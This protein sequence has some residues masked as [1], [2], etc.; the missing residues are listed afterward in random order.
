MEI[1][2]RYHLC[3]LVFAPFFPAE[4]VLM[5]VRPR[6]I[7]EKLGQLS[8]GLAGAR[9][10]RP[11][12]PN[13]VALRRPLLLVAAIV[14]LGGGVLVAGRLA[15]G[16]LTAARPQSA[17]SAPAN[18]VCGEPC[19]LYQTVW[20]GDILLADSAQPYVDR[21]GY[22][23]PFE[24]V[25]PLLKADFVVGNSEGPITER[26]EQYFPDEPWDYSARPQAAEGLAEV[27]FDA[28]GLSNNHALDRGPEGLADTLRH[29][30]EAGIQPF[31][32]GMD[33][34][35]AAAPLLIPTPHGTVAAL[36][37][38]EPW[39]FG[40]VAGPGQPGTLAYSDE[41]IRRHGELARQAGARWV[42][43][44]VHWGDNY[45]TVKPQQRRLAAAFARA[46]Y[47][48][49]VGHHPHVAQE[50]DVVDGMPVLY[51]LGNFAFGSPG[52]HSEQFP[53][54][55]VVA[56]TFFGREG[57]QA[58]ELTCIL[59]DNKIVR[60]QPRPCDE[61]Q[62]RKV[63]QGLGPHVAWKDGKG[64]VKWAAQASAP[65]RR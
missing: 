47:D 58:V 40:A 20:V 48:L 42:V 3:G 14:V 51:S 17:S 53:G 15:V 31:G 1:V 30:R 10:P 41:A 6:F 21:H 38:S 7:R 24:H 5:W 32:A 4:R 28:L 26:R 35:E 55:S 65:P 63:M 61:Q 2:F 8:G 18:G 59:T 11:V 60:Y 46:G 22:A 45:S 36:A 62:A 43:A 29:L 34:D 19:D 13:A 9:L 33:G 52:R 54:Y 44:Y 27:G 56:R 39:R 23:W 12:W 57:L 16:G 64:L 49:V 25:R 50:V 37:L